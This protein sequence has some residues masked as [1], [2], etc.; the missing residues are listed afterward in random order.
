MESCVV[1]V[2]VG[3]PG[4]PSC[5]RIIFLFLCVGLLKET[6][7]IL[8][9]FS[10]FILSTEQTDTFCHASTNFYSQNRKVRILASVFKRA[11]PYW[12]RIDIPPK[13]NIET[14]ENLSLNSGGKPIHDL[15]GLGP[16]DTFL[17]Q[18]HVS[19]IFFLSLHTTGSTHLVVCVWCSLC[20]LMRP[21]VVGDLGV[22]D[23]VLGWTRQEIFPLSLPLSRDG[24]ETSHL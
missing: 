10:V 20:I 24:C 12:P 18:I 7:H 15:S 11:L 9:A 1:D 13:L 21:S 14:C 19:F 4:E 16:S 17:L 5:T 8:T 3:V 6:S 23:G 22:E 2:I